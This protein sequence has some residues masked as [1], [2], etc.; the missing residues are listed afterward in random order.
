[1]GQTGGWRMNT[2]P[3]SDR[4]ST[5]R[6]LEFRRLPDL[7]SEAQAP[8]AGE[9]SSFRLLPD[10]SH[11]KPPSELAPPPPS[12]R[13]SQRLAKAAAGPALV[14]AGG[15]AGFLAPASLQTSIRAQLD[16]LAQRV[17][18]LVAGG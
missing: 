16:A 4:A 3:L 15:L 9:T 13:L 18:V 10:L 7:A 11:D 17:S 1:M 8:A 5:G 2:I 14:L 6:T 12:R